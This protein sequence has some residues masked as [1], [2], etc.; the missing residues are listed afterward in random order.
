MF[1]LFQYVMQSHFCTLRINVFF[2]SPSSS[3]IF[4]V[5]IFIPSTNKFLVGY[6]S[7]SLKPEQKECIKCIFDGKDVF[8]WLPTGFGKSICYEVLPFMFD[9]KLGTDNSLVIVVSPLVSLTVDQVRSLRSRS[10]K[11][12]VMFCTTL[13]PRRSS[14]LGGT[15][16]CYSRTKNCYCSLSEYC[17]LTQVQTDSHRRTTT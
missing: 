1:H 9:K 3:A 7:M 14:I 4:S 15:L 11:A 17:S 13:T 8:V 6:S 2:T 16:L 12:S 10:V 5:R